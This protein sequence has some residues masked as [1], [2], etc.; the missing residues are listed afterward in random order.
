MQRPCKPREIPVLRSNTLHT[1]WIP[2]NGTTLLKRALVYLLGNAF[3]QS[4]LLKYAMYNFHDVLHLYS[5]SLKLYQTSTSFPVLH[6]LNWNPSFSC[7]AA[8]PTH[9]PLHAL[10]STRSTNFMAYYS[11]SNLLLFLNDIKC[12]SPKLDWYLLL[13]PIWLVLPTRQ[14]NSQHQKQHS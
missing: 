13:D 10:P 6:V 7:H 2:K 14:H 3:P 11:R 4:Q 1:N 5:P 9:S 12:D 8:T